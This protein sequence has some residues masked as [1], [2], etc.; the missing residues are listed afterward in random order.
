LTYIFRYPST[1][2]S[3]GLSQ[4]SLGVLV[5]EWL[6]DPDERMDLI[7]R[8]FLLNTNI[9]HAALRGGTVDAASESQTKAAFGHFEGKL[10]PVRDYTGDGTRE[11][12]F[13]LKPHL[14]FISASYMLLEQMQIEWTD[15]QLDKDT[16]GSLCDC[17]EAADRQS[18][19][20]LE[21]PPV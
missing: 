20:L 14:Q 5:L 8:A 11:M 1:R 15:R 12:P 16:S 19:F 21:M 17:Y 13:R 4:I 3:N 10:K 2:P 18:W 7:S 9:E 6:C